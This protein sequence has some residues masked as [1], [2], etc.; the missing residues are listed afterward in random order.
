MHKNTDRISC[1]SLK[2]Q[3]VGRI[4][5]NIAFVVHSQ[6]NQKNPTI[7]HP[8]V[9]LF[10]FSRGGPSQNV[11]ELDLARGGG[12]N[13]FLH[14]MRRRGIIPFSSGPILPYTCERV[15]KDG[16]IAKE[17]RV[18]TWRYW[19]RCP[20]HSTRSAGL[21]DDVIISEHNVG[22]KKSIPR[23]K[24][25]EK[26]KKAPA[27]GRAPFFSSSSRPARETKENAPFANEP[28]QEHSQR[29]S[30]ASGRSLFLQRTRLRPAA[31]RRHL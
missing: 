21:R 3:T 28:Q 9:L 8:H 1:I 26:K 27:C 6:K 24:H 14:K 5:R 10:V 12:T 20:R 15:Q 16:D 17:G 23:V 31:N 25:R 30:W 11:A 7:D 19:V 2:Q 22:E 18:M 29:V 13:H 4:G